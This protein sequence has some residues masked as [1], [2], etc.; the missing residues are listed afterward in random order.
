MRRCNAM[1]LFNSPSLDRCLLVFSKW[2][3]VYRGNSERMSG[4]K[5]DEEAIQ[6]LQYM[7]ADLDEK[8]LSAETMKLLEKKRIDS[9]QAV[10]KM[11]EPVKGTDRPVY[12]NVGRA[13]MLTD[14]D[15]IV[16]TN[17][18][19]IVECQKAVQN[20]ESR[21]NDLNA[22]YK[23]KEDDVREKLRAIQLKSQSMLGRIRTSTLVQIAAG[24]FLIG[25]TAIYLAQKRVQ[26]RVR[27]LPHYSEALKIVAH[28]EKARD[29]LGPPIVVGNVDLSDRHHNYIDKTKSMLRLPVSG[30]IDSGFLNV[31]AERK[32][33]EDEF[34]TIYVDLELAEGV[35]S[36]LATNL[37]IHRIVPH[38]FFV[39]QKG[40]PSSPMIISDFLHSL[41]NMAWPSWLQ[42]HV[43]VLLLW[44]SWSI[45]YVDLN[46][47]EYLFWLFLP[48]FVAFVVPVLLL[49]FIY[50]C[51]I[52][53]HIY[54]LRHEIVE[55]YH[56][57]YWNGARTS[58][59]SFWDAVGYLWHGYE[60]TGLENIPDDGPA[61]L[62]Y[63]HGTL[64]IDV[65]YL[66]AKCILYKKRT[67]HCVG[68]KFI[69][70][71]PGWGM[72]CKVFCVTPG[73]VE[74][75]VQ[76]LNDGNLLCIAPG[77]VREALFSD[78]ATYQI[79]WGKRLGFAKVVLGSN[80]A[81]IPM[82]TENCR[83]AFRTPHWGRKMFRWLYEKTRL[84][85]CPI[86]GGFPVKM[87]THLGK[88]MRFPETTTPE[89][90]KRAVKKEVKD[91]IREHQR[92]PGSIM[93]GIIQRFYDKRHSK[94]D[95][96]LVDMTGRRTEETEAD[97]NG[98]IQ[99]IDERNEPR[100][101][102]TQTQNG[103]HRD[104][105]SDPVRN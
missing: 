87:R 6:H 25:S 104:G 76:N 26:H 96:L 20:I 2:R 82:F 90:V 70:K 60:V 7:K 62:L 55:A 78:A 39:R 98:T 75:C 10:L 33:T 17:E 79:M 19:R 38:S 63:Y 31:Y 48:I 73:T 86:Y 44:V 85:I 101:C 89:E 97:H 52:F 18:E 59:A 84:P 102:D 99:E 14:A 22:T 61:L 49:L 46:Y 15:S 29:S 67:L 65:Y 56:T 4:A 93:R 28:H 88:V 51:V 27:S 58:I 35:L 36:S 53:L 16:K 42:P 1:K 95:V 77:G 68:D 30:E 43:E 83:D 92:L 74:D 80:T 37:F 12:H 94:T 71:I 47:L 54:R 81:V 21:Q 103:I 105:S 69:F 91:L 24:G 41:E 72:I 57:S 11:M 9:A 5:R 8:M 64:P 32:S 34:Q 23:K 100:M 50:G 66:I 40:L 45:D 3:T 13:Y